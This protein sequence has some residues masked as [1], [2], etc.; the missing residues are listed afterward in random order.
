MAVRCEPRI[1]PPLTP[2]R[3]CL[4]VVLSGYCSSRK[5]FWISEATFSAR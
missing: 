3:W 4:M 5:S 2:S 1:S